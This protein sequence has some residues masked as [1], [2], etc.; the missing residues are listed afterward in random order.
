MASN[1]N[2]KYISDERFKAA[3]CRIWWPGAS[4]VLSLRGLFIAELTAV[5][6]RMLRCP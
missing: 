6:P 5:K 2:D 1:E 3:F 4:N